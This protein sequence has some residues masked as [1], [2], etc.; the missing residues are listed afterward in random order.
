MERDPYDIHFLQPADVMFSRGPGGVLQGVIEGALYSEILVYRTFPFKYTSQ[1]ISI[2]NAKG[3]ELG[4]IEDISQLDDE[5]AEELGRELQFRYFLPRVTRVD[6]VKEKSELWVWELQTTLGPTRMAMRNLHEH[7]QYPGEGR[8]ILT[9]INGKRC[10]ILDWRA[11][12]QHSRK[13]LTDVI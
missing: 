13:Q 8:L 1:Y 10:E 4:I 2:R 3:D 7:V 5:S 11:L 9:D 12:D 6:S